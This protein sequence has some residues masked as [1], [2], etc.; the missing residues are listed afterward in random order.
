MHPVRFHF[1]KIQKIV[2]NRQ[3]RRA[4]VV[5]FFYIIP[6]L[7]IQ[8]RFQS[9]VGHADDSVHG[10]ANLMT[11]ISQEKRFRLEGLLRFFMG[12]IQF[13]FFLFKF[14]YIHNGSHQAAWAPVRQAKARNPVQ[15]LMY[16]AIG[17]AP[18][19][20]AIHHRAR[21]NNLTLL[22]V[23]LLRVLWRDMGHLQ[24]RSA[25]ERFP[26]HLKRLLIGFIAA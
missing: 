18:R 1:R 16:T 14:T 17:K 23:V 8:V 13:F 9:Q 25:E 5:N 20:L 15:Q 10:C 22:L 26:A 24:N 7:I 2:D 4:G 12:L 3:Q 11:D 19:P 21:G 6:L